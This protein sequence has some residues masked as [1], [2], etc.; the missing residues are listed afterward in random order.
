MFEVGER[1]KWVVS[2]GLLGRNRYHEGEVV[3]IVAEGV[4]PMGCCGDLGYTGQ[5]YIVK[6]QNTYGKWSQYWMDEK[7]LQRA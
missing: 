7:S 3:E 5:T 2:Q 4:I 1:V 6:R